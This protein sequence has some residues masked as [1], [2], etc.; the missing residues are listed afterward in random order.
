MNLVDWKKTLGI[1]ILSAGL[2]FSAFSPA[3]FAEGQ[4]DRGQSQT[5]SQQTVPFAASKQ[6]GGPFDIG[7]VND[8]KLM[9]SLIKQG[10]VDKNDSRAKQQKTLQHYVTK[11]AKEADKLANNSPQEV[12][13]ARHDMQKKAGLKPK[14]PGKPGHGHKPPKPGK[15]GHGH[16]P[17]KP[18]GK[19]H[20]HGRVAPIEKEQWNGKVRTDKILVLLI[21]YPD[22]PHNNMT[23]ADD[24][25]YMYPDFNRDHYKDMIF[26][27]NGYEGPDGQ[28]FISL[29]KFYNEQSGGSYDVDGD[30]YGWY[31]AE[32][33]AAYY[34][35]N[36][37][38]DGNDKNPRALVQEAL[39]D[40][41]ADGVDL[42]R[43]DQE[44]PYDLD[45]DGDYREPDGIID[46]LMVIHSGVGEEAGGGTLGGDAI[47]SHSWNLAQP[48]PIPG[49]KADVPYWGGQI[50]GY[51]YTV[52][53]EDG[54]AG[55][56]SHEYGHNLGLPDEYDIQYSTPFDEPVG[57]WSI[58]SAGSWGGKIAGTEPTGFGAYDKEFLQ[59]EM[60]ELNWFKGETIN[61][62]DLNHRGVSTKL[63][64][65]SV[66]GTNADGVRVNLPDKKTVVNEPANGDY[67]YF[68]GS[69]NNLDHSMTTTVDLTNA[70]TAQLTFEAWYDIEKDW[71]YA[72]V[73]V[74]QGDTWVSIPGNL[75]TTSNPNGQNPGN[76]ITGTSDGWVEA[77][78]D[79]SDYAGQKVTFKI[80]YWTDVAVAQPGLYVD[81]VQ[82]TVD[83]KTLL[84]DG[85]E[86]TDSAFDVDGFTRN[87]GVNYT[88]HYYLLEWRNWAAADTA[89]AH[90]ARGESLMTYDPGLVIW[91]VDNKYDNNVEAQHPGHGFL[92]VVDAHQNVAKWS[93]GSVAANRYQ[94]Q[95][96]AF[97][98]K[99]TDNMFLDYRDLLGKYLAEKS[100]RP[101]PVF[102]D[103]RDY[104]N[105]DN[106]YIGVQLP[107]YGLKVHVTGQSKDDSVGA[108]HIQK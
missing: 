77:N 7:L 61:L 82:V 58:M 2:V 66:K 73:Q 95:D 53:P 22:F 41:A 59:N 28:N 15:P 78:F 107:S 100:Q 29:R 44:D 56:F 99:K 80:N 45:G 10:V 106:P 38:G 3:V 91:Y 43:Y 40:A 98:K 9:K 48:T 42:N 60:P 84:S 36:I 67:E 5:T 76:G 37:G 31:T 101:E 16:K 47:W 64:E 50:A 26:G 30:V 65:A 35:G 92:N 6:S 87:Q 25:I 27:K 79:L 86:S 104:Y 88:D 18:P 81:D 33:P 97:S 68:S 63:D 83:G 8:D 1:P 74:K 13:K 70:G 46:H 62:E 24:P 75:T 14:P 85:A 17:P 52:Q 93:D 34:G 19:G 39:T 32:H 55:V 108:I 72:S 89:L 54:A 20:G 102:D 57:Y 69:G 11:R 21:Q 94:V 90:I 71:D 12:K 51:A 96:A 23:S 4:Q 103:H 105:P 49:T